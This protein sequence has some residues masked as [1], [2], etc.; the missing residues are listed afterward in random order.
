MPCFFFSVSRRCGAR[1]WGAGLTAEAE[2]KTL[3]LCLPM[4]AGREVTVYSDKEAKGG[5]MPEAQMKRA[6][7]GKDGSL[8]VT[9]QPS[10]GLIVE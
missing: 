7:V 8:K 3:K 10:G 6:R 4:L 9:I 2:A 1:W 5:A